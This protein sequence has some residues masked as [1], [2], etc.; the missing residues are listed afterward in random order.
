MDPR[1]E[2]NDYLR[3]QIIIEEERRMRM[4]AEWQEAEYYRQQ[5]EQLPAKIEILTKIPE[6][7]ENTTNG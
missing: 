5:Q 2:D 3:E 7:N 4:E 6:T 1:E